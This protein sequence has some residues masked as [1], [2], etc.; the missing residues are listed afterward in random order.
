[1]HYQNHHDFDPYV[2]KVRA[3]ERPIYRALTPTD[4]ERLIREF[5]LQLKLGSVRLDY[6]R[7]KFGVDPSRRFAGPFRALEDWGYLRVEGDR[8]TINRS[9]LLQV[10]R[11]LHEFFLPEHRQAR[12]A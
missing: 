6:F 11:L 2:A 5:I 4:D 9:G 12:Y 1:V 10:D 7:S 8:V 3:G